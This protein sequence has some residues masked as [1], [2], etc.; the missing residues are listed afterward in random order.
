ML[1]GLLIW[2]C[3]FGM[4]YSFT[5]LACARGF[6]RLNWLGVGIVP[7]AIGA[8]TL[9]AVSAASGITILSIRYAGERTAQE[10]ASRFVHWM[11]A[12]IGALALLAIVWQALPV[13]LVPTCG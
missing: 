10:N 13:L 5:A 4:I 6:W 8:A 7:W 1:S 11:T 3:H 2:A 12:A 9:V